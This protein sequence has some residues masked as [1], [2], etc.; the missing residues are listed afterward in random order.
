MELDSLSAQKKRIHFI[1][2]GGSGIFP[3]VQ[4]FSEMGHCI[5]GSDN[6]TG[7]NVT[8]EIAMGATVFMGHS[9]EQVHGAE[10]V[11]FSAAIPRDNPELK[12]AQR[13][14]LPVFERSEV[15][16]WLS[17]RYNDCIGVAGTH[18]KTTASALLTQILV[19]AGLDPTVVIGGKLP[20]IGGSGRA[21]KSPIMIVE[22]CEYVDT[23]LKL[24]P[25][26]A[27][28][29]NVDA[30]H[31]EYFGDLKGVVRS[32]NK[33]A[34]LAS[35]LV[36]ANG[37]DENVLEALKGVKT[38]ILTFGLKDGCDY[39]ARNI[40]R[41]LPS[42]T[43][44]DLMFRGE[45]ITE[46]SLSVPGEHNI[47]N[48]LA[49]CAAALSAGASPEQIAAQ[50]KRFTGA[51]R[52]FEML[53][54]VGGVAIADDYAHHPAE[55][56]ATLKTASGLGYKR[57]WAVF[58]PYTYSRTKLLLNDFA[59]ALAIADRVVMSAIMGGREN[60]PGDI[61]TGDLAAKIPCSVWFETFEEIAAYILD[62]AVEGDLVITMGCGDVYK[63]ARLLFEG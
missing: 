21:G 62:N 54:K 8:A 57:V 7:D 55:I 24:R 18:G 33:Y 47:L 14:G 2:I 30:D 58:Q 11:I 51:A 43:E 59:S 39:T 60:D 22:A 12:E 48:A 6:N 20:L 37:D 34:G 4:I 15:L 19:G 41:P 42:R 31:L 25:A 1:G 28:I 46:I 63:C 36:I 52:R 9:A 35:R 44:F 56:A 10:L 61:K 17:A 32:F 53:G 5:Q 3:L 45:L 38:Q 50:T 26:V 29:L 16:G 23:F 49:A 13:L 27:V 40:R